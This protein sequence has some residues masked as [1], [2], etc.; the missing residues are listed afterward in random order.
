MPCFVV[1]GSECFSVQ[2]A[3]ISLNRFNQLILVMVKLGVFS[4]VRTEYYFDEL[5]L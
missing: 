1:K 2:T 4:E 3:N 5:R